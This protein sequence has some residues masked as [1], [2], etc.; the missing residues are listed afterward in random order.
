MYAVD[1]H[2]HTRFFHGHERAAEY[3]DLVGVRLLAGVARLRNLDAVALTNHDYYRSFDL[4]GP[5]GPFAGT[6]PGVEVSTTHGHVLVIGPDPPRRTEPGEL[7]PEE[8]VELAHDRGCA[9]VVAH[10]YRNSTVKNVDVDFDAIEVNGKHPR[11]EQWVRE[12][13]EDQDLPLVGG[14]DA[15]YPVEVGRAYTAIDADELTPESV[16]AAIR[17]GRVEPRVHRGAFNRL[18]RR[19]YRQ[20]HEDKGYLQRPEWLDSP[21]A[22]EPPEPGQ[23]DG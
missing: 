20:I 6:I 22:G 13:A 4:G 15:H 17:D 18:L 19:F 23:V 8:T 12:L 2:S 3:F 10:P 9:A 21:G 11:T 1:L 16:A 14:S 5:T 7:S